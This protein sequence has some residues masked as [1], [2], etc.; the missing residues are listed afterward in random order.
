MD[1]HLDDIRSLAKEGQ[2]LLELARTESSG[3]SSVTL[4]HGDAQRAVLIGLT[5]G[6][7]LAEHDAPRAATLQLV[8]GRARLF[9]AED[10]GPEWLL[11]EG[12]LV[13]IPDSRHGVDALSDSVLLL[14]VAL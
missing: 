9:V 5:A 7:T 4:V 8:S 2:A 1:E 3:R 10:Q 12:D 14:T 11:Q 6:S 13:P